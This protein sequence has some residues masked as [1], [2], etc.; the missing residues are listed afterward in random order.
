ME[1]LLK[2]MFYGY[3]TLAAGQAPE[4]RA[5]VYA[6]QL[7]SF[8]VW[9][10]VRAIRTKAREHCPSAGLLVEECERIVAGLRAERSKIDKLLA[11]EIDDKPRLAT[12]AQRLA[13]VVDELRRKDPDTGERVKVNERAEALRALETLENEPISK[14]QLSPS[15][16]ALVSEQ[17][18]RAGMAPLPEPSDDHHARD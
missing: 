2:D 5:R 18:V 15:L 11:S 9:A 3:P 6:S 14:V 7:A 17:N 4:L 1:W 12:A 13:G 10:V 16:R 8:P